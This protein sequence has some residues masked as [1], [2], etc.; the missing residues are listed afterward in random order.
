V[1]ALEQR[2]PKISKAEFKIQQELKIRLNFYEIA[3]Q[4]I[5]AMKAGA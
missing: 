5:L 2:Q 3:L 1:F 4:Q